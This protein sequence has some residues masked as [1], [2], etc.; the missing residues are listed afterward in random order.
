MLHPHTHTPAHLP[1]GT[2]EL[3]VSPSSRPP[4]VRPFLHPSLP[5]SLPPFLPSSLPPFLPS[6]LPPFLPSF[7]PSF[8]PLTFFRSLLYF[9][10][11][12]C[13]SISF[14][15]CA[16]CSNNQ[17][18]P[19]KRRSDATAPKLKEC[20]GASESGHCVQ[21]AEV[22]YSSEYRLVTPGSLNLV[23]FASVKIPKIK[24]GKPW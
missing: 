11:V 15:T 8:L 16:Y 21:P 10:I 18:T 17:R 20:L 2:Q 9:C 6:S 24:G 5:P 3:F 19:T 14:Q 12:L 13:P 7:L 1:E 4:S 22:A 23:S